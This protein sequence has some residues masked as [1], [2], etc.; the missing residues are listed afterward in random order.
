[1]DN[2]FLLINPEALYTGGYFDIFRVIHQLK[3]NNKSSFSFDSRIKANIKAIYPGKDENIIRLI[4]NLDGDYIDDQLIIIQKAHAKQKSGI[5]MDVYIERAAPRFF[6][7]LFKT[8][9]G[10][11]PQLKIY[12]RVKNKETGNYKVA[13]CTV[14]NSLPVLKF[15]VDKTPE[16]EILLNTIIEIEG[17]QFNLNDFAASNFL[18][19]KDHSSMISHTF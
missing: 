10:F 7:G 12:H 2:S 17:K 14:S 11:A 13:P 4:K 9:A 18:L 1:M 16:Q 15:A 6:H 3:I 19:E 5:S 8:L